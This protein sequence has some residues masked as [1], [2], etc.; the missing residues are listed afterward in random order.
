[1]T[2][3]RPGHLEAVPER[4]VADDSG[5]S[6][7]MIAGGIDTR[8]G[9]EGQPFGSAFVFGGGWGATEES[10]GVSYCQSSLYN[11]RAV[12]VEY[13]EK[14]M[15][16]VIWEHARTIDT[17][18]AGRFRGGFAATYAFEALSDTFCTPIVDSSKFPAEGLGGGGGGV[19]SF[20]V[21]LKKDPTGGIGT[22]N[23]LVPAERMIPL[24]GAFDEE[25]RPDMVNGVWG[26]GTLLQT[27]KPTGYVL[28]PGEIMRIQTACAAGYGDPLDRDPAAVLNDVANELVSPSAAAELYGVR[29]DTDT[30]QVDEGATTALREQMRAERGDRWATPLAYPA[31]WPVTEAELEPFIHAGVVGSARRVH[32]EV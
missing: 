19:M 31:D 24:F 30:L 18:G 6:G 23:G 10:D 11:C 14:S 8:P 25:G 22:W 28:H 5:T 32:T 29:I 1:M 21:L 26:Q 4:A 12:I 15:P 16:V 9:F 13:I 17:A 27:S 20:A 2:R 7:A 3:W